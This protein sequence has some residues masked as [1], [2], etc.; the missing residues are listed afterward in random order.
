MKELIIIG[1]GPA[2]ISL[3][4]EA[5]TQGLKSDDIL[6]LEQAPEHSF[7]IRKYYPDSKPVTANYKG[8]EANCLGVLCL[9]DTTKEETLSL[10]DKTINDFNIKVQYKESVQKIE[11]TKQGYF[12]IDTN[13]S[14]YISKA[15]SIAIGMMGRP[16]RPDYNLPST[17]R[18]CIHFD[19][20]SKPITNSSVLVVGGGDSASEYV[21]YLSQKNNNVDI[22]YRRDNFSRMNN[23][24]KEALENLEKRKKVN[25]LYKTDIES[26]EQQDQ[27]KIKVNFKEA[28]TK[29]Y[30]HIVYALGG[31]TPHNFLK[32]IGIEF[33]G[34]E[35]ELTGAHETS[36]PGL[37]LV[38][39]LSAGKKGGSIISAFNSSHRA[40]AQICKDYLHCDLK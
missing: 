10:L 18:D 39:D 24:N 7:S 25:I 29:A 31:S 37:F 12:I 35:P 1:A 16:N 14:R 30:D 32:L 27:P 33:I 34:G 4:A 36:I 9:R 38:G 19:I 5:I 17:L 23:L 11:Y 8:A 22:S 28:P 40:M 21:Q 13:K 26:I 3:A 6:L 20:T 15:C 2:G